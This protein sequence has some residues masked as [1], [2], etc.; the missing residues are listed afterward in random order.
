MLPPNAIVSPGAAD[1]EKS[2][3]LINQLAALRTP[4]KS[5]SQLCTEIS[6]KPSFSGAA[7]QITDITLYWRPASWLRASRWWMPWRG[8]DADDGLIERWE[9]LPE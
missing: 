3:D 9:A 1:A 7:L 4:T 2:V 6:L 8:G 5:P